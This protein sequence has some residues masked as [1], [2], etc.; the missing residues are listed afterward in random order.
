MVLSELRISVN[1][2]PEKYDANVHRLEVET[3]MEAMRIMD[4]CRHRVFDAGL[5]MPKELKTFLDTASKHELLDA[6]CAKMFRGLGLEGFG[7]R[8]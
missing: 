4:A 7:L 6:L 1:L 5:S 3:S 8:V 2:Q